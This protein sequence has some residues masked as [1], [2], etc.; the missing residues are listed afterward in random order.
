MSETVVETYSDTDALVVA[1]GD[2]LIAAIA[3]AVQARGQ[4]F[5]AL[6]GGGTGVKLLKYLGDQDA[7]INWSAVHLFWGDERYVPEADDERNDKQAREA[8]LDRI[9]IPD[10]NVHAMP[11]SDGE[12]GSDID[13]AA[14]AYEQ[15]LAANAP[16][17]QPTPEFD[18]HLLG[19]GEEGHVNSL[20]PH[21]PATAEKSRF[22][23]GVEDS[24]KPPPRR[25]TLTFPAVNRSREVWLVVSGGGKAEAVAAALGGAEAG[26]WPAA[27]AIGTD[28]TVWLLDAAAA[29]K[30]S[31]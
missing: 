24:P 11:A 26:D 14:L 3:Q 10:R 31:D 16:D 13:A 25:I 23:V 4:A 15:V 22:V 29:S 19:M 20:F 5:I 2:R 18:V 17:G 6:T 1:A 8:L 28:K 12:F 9:D 27:G 7:V 21:T 30:I